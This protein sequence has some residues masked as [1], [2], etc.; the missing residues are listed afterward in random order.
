MPEENPQ[1][2]QDEQ[3]KPKQTRAEQ[4]QQMANAIAEAGT[5]LQTARDDA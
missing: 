2:P 5:L 1:P 4:D 3:P